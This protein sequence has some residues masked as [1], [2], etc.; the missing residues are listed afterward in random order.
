MQN[1]LIP[2]HSHIPK[3]IHMNAIISLNFLF[4]ILK[5]CFEN[6]WPLVAPILQEIW[7]KISVKDFDS[8]F[9]SSPRS[10]V[11][12][13]LASHPAGPGSIPGLCNIL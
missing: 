4:Y 13:T 3:F 12:S 8:S 10:K 5:K 11:V 7:E 6:K 1:E 2:I 9:A